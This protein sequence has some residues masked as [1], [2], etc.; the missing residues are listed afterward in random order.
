[1]R[2]RIAITTYGETASW[3]VWSRPAVVL[4]QTYVEAVAAAG[5]VPV[6]LPAGDAEA[7]GDALRAVDG[8]VL[9]G[10]ADI[11]P[12]AYGQDALPKTATT[13]PGRDAFEAAALGAALDR[14]LPVL[15][16]CRGMQLLN[17]ARGGTL[18]QHLPDRVGHD[19]HQ[20]Q[21]GA[22]GAHPVRLDEHSRLGR[23]LG[24]RVDVPTYHHQAVDAVGDGLHA[25]GWADDGTI[26][27]IEAMDAPWAVGVQ[28]H[29]EEGNDLRLFEAFVGRAARVAAA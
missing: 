23:I 9:A 4:P 6:L 17:V 22:F 21:V 20:P 12:R 11:D 13:R 28:W 3:G 8:L 2:P 27:A 16:V 29:P 14:Q 10:G 26:E 7:A 1:M 24:A 19:R 18:V 25:V 5:G 15:G